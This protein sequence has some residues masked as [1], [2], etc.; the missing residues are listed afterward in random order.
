MYAIT[1]TGRELLS[2]HNDT[3]GIRLRHLK[4]YEKYREFRRPNKAEANSEAVESAPDDDATPEERIESAMSDIRTGVAA[5]VLERV[6]QQTPEFF[7]Q[8]VLDVLQA[9][10]YGRTSPGAAKR[11]GRSGDGGVDGVI[12][13]DRLGL[14]LIYVQA[15]RWNQTVVGRP[16]IQQFVGALNGQLASKGV[17]ITTSAFS[18]EAI[19]YA[20]TVSPRVVLIDGK[21][22]SEYMVECEVGASHGAVYR[23]PEIDLDYFESDDVASPPS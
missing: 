21:E 14:D 20:E 12:R 3:D 5:E 4:Q 9:M 2:A 23:V 19:T 6:L 10:G 16:E 1:D 22:L 8:V 13:E 11:L 15:K 18:R 17:F 7:E